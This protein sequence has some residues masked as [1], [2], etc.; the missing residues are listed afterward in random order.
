MFTH[1]HLAETK[2][3]EI[4]SY[5][6]VKRRRTRRVSRSVFL[7]RRGARNGNPGIEVL[8]VSDE[9]IAEPF[10][11]IPSAY[12]HTISPKSGF[13]KITTAA[14]MTSTRSSTISRPSLPTSHT[15]NE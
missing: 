3:A 9:Q 5:Q 12:P 14:G 7:G 1:N 11:P 10:T 2:R 15:A 6:L 4:S 8:E 13:S